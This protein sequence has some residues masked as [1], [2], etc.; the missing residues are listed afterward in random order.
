MKHLAEEI[1][2]NQVD[3][4]AVPNETLNATA[5]PDALL[6][7][8]DATLSR[9]IANDRARRKV[10]AILLAIQYRHQEMNFEYAGI[11]PEQSSV[12]RISVPRTKFRRCA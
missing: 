11:A 5:L 6:R 9:R 4:S 3:Y 12:L 10:R 1:A 8:L 7:C 2:N